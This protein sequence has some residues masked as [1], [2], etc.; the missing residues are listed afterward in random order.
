M[1]RLIASTV[2]TLAAVATTGAQSQPLEL[3]GSLTSAVKF[4]DVPLEQVLVTL[5]NLAGVTLEFDASVA[6]ED[7]VKPVGH[8][9]LVQSRFADA[10]K[11][12]TKA[13]GLTYTMVDAKTVRIS[14]G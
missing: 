7:R 6:E 4:E 3:A 12:I 8:L 14:K 13:A 2:I 11:F 9:T 5:A 1:R 10:F